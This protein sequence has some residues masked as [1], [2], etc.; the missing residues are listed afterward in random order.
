VQI[1]W[2]FKTGERGETVNQVWSLQNTEHDTNLLLRLRIKK[3]HNPWPRT[4]AAPGSRGGLCPQILF[5]GWRCAL[6][7]RAHPTFCDVLTPLT[8]STAC[9]V[10][11]EQGGVWEVVALARWVVGR[12]IMP[13]SDQWTT[14]TPHSR[15]TELTGA[16]RAWKRGHG[17]REFIMG[18]WGFSFQP[19][20][21]VQGQ[22]VSWQVLKLHC[23]RRL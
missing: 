4:L 7:M 2:V 17:E 21:G 23:H 19:S 9:S 5:I 16:S 20:N 18:V 8:S 10:G 15:T 22:V 1:Q 11:C 3:P 13:C 14:G 6:A 12:S